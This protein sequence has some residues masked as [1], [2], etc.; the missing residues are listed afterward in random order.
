[1]V[2]PENPF[3]AIERQLEDSGLPNPD[4]KIK[5]LLVPPEVALAGL[6]GNLKGFQYKLPKAKEADYN[7]LDRMYRIW[8]QDATRFFMGL[9][10]ENKISCFE[11]GPSE[12]KAHRLRRLA[13][14]YALFEEKQLFPGRV[15]VLDYAEIK[16]VAPD[17]YYDLPLGNQSEINQLYLGNTKKEIAFSLHQMTRS[18][19]DGGTLRLLSRYANQV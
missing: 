11:V 13:D 18:L 10:D 9:K 17:A 19:L 4:K 12:V 14:G 16:P 2:N 15:Y 7:E 3:D 6:L 1:L 8:S 5:P